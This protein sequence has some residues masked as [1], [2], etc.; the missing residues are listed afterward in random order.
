MGATSVDGINWRKH[1][2]PVLN[3]P[4]FAWAALVNEAA[5]V[6]GPDERFY[7]FFS[8]TGLDATSESVIGIARADHPFGPYEVY[9][10]PI[11]TPTHTWE[12]TEIIAPDVLIEDAER[13]RMWYMGVIGEFE[14]FSIGY[15]EASWPLE[16][17]T[18]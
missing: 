15:A 17:T 9:P 5:I 3:P 13:V 6:Q 18:E 14:D 16:W 12:G 4:P 11:L 2:E 8:A 10:E 7:L 1:D